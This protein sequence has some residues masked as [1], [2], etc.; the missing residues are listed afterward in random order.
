MKKCFK[1]LLNCR[2]CELARCCGVSWKCAKGIRSAVKRVLSTQ[3][4]KKK[5]YA[6]RAESA[7]VKVRRNIV[8]KLANTR[9]KRNGREMV[10]FP[11]SSSILHKLRESGFTRVSRWTIWRDA[12]ARG[13]K[14][15]VRPKVPC[16]KP[17]VLEQRRSFCD[18]WRKTPIK[19]CKRIGF[20]DEHTICCNDY[21]PRL[22][23][24]K[25]RKCVVSRERMRKQNVP[26]LN[27]WALISHGFKSNL[28]FFDGTLDGLKYTRCVLSKV[29]N[30]LLSHNIIL[31]QDG[32]RPHIRSNV[33]A[34]LERNGIQTVA[35][36]PPYSPDLSPIENVW[37]ELDKR[38]SLRAPQ[39]LEDLR[40]AA[41]EAWNSI[42]ISLINRYVHSFKGRC[43][44]C[45][46]NG[47]EL[48]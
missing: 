22:M 46:T 6:K 31:Q 12:R 10:P 13:L 47:G 39:T 7:S 29:K 27:V 4:R 37:A 18:V 40:S 15:F 3:T 9:Q 33:R 16:K 23:F 26:R 24:A 42:P 36:W 41:V 48:K 45:F 21:S 38:I 1:A 44:R 17:R 2:P 19:T 32:A 25:N 11:S 20:T 34:Y 14:S 30:D 5:S 28:I 35:N 43:E 8:C